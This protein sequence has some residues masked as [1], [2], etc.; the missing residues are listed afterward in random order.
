MLAKITCSS[1]AGPGTLR[2]SFR[3]S[4]V[5]VA[6]LP[7]TV[8]GSSLVLSGSLGIESEVGSVFEVSLLGCTGSGVSAESSI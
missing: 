4:R 2:S 7:V 5:A 3:A 8:K 1:L 6:M